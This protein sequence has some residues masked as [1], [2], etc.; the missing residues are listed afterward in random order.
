VCTGEEASP[1]GDGKKTSL[2]YRQSGKKVRVTR[3]PGLLP[4]K[5]ER[6]PISTMAEAEIGTRVK[7]PRKTPVA[8]F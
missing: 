7:G 6:G 5:G 2:A 8:F 3:K 1:L 4:T